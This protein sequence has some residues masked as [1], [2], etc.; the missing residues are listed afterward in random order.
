[1]ASLDRITVFPV[2][3]LDGVSLD[4]ATVGERGALELDREYALFDADG[5]YV[6]GKATAEIH[7]LRS[8]FDP[9]SHELAIGVHGEGERRQ[10]RLSDADDRAALSEWLSGFFGEPVTVERDDAGGYPDDE[11][12]HGPTVISTGTIREVADWFDLSVESVRRRFR[13]NLV[14]DADD[15]FWEDRLFADRGEVVPFEI[16]DVSFEGVNPCQRCVV[17]TRD[18]DTGAE[19]DGFRERFIEM[20]RETLP[21][22]TP[23]ERFDHPYRLMLNTSVPESG[24]GERVSVGDTVTVGEATSI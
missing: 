1:M 9:E 19:L 14:V 23:S 21:E 18:P 12:L 3:S 5:A 17:P 10:F 4:S 13:A 8:A 20:R 15:P 24:W 6:N 2:K 22:W 11:E 7:R 16:G